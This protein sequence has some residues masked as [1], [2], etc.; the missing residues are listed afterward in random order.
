MSESH[1]VSLAFGNMTAGLLFLKRS[2]P[3]SLAEAW[4]VMQRAFVTAK[5]GSFSS[6]LLHLPETLA[7]GPHFEQSLRILGGTIQKTRMLP[8][9]GD[10]IKLTELF[11]KVAFTPSPITERARQFIVMP[12]GANADLSR[13]IGALAGLSEWR[14]SLHTTTGEKQ[15]HFFFLE[16]VSGMDE[17]LPMGLPGVPVVLAAMAEGVFVPPGLVHPFLPEYRFLFPPQQAGQRHCWVTNPQGLPEYFLLQETPDSGAPL[18]RKVTLKTVRSCCSFAT[19]ATDKIQVALELQ[20]SRTREGLPRDASRTVYRIETRAGE[21]GHLLLRF[22]DHAEAGIENFTYYIRPLGEGPNALIE[23]YLLAEERIQDEQSWPGL[24]RFYS[25]RILEDLNLP[26]FLP[27]NRH[28]AP[29]IEGLLRAAD[30]DEPLLLQLAETT[31]FGT[32]ANGYRADSEP[33]IA[34]LLPESNEQDWS[35]LHLENGRPLAEAIQATSRTY[36]REAIRRVLRVNPPSLEEEREHYEER[37]ID[38]GTREA[39]EIAELT[40]ECAQELR[41]AAVRMDAELQ[42]HELRL[43]DVEEVLSL[44]GALVTEHLPLSVCEYADRTLQIISEL[45]APQRSFL[46][47]LDMRANQLAQLQEDV[48]AL[49]RQATRDVERLTVERTTAEKEIENN[50]ERLAA[51]V[52]SLTSAANEL[53]GSVARAEEAA[54]QAVD[55]MQMRQAVLNRQLSAVMSLETQV[56]QEDARLDAVQ[57]DIERRERDAAERRRLQTVRRQ[58]L[59]RREREVQH[60]IRLAEQEQA[61]LNAIENVEIP[62]L[63][64]QLRDLEIEVAEFQKR[65]V[66]VS[67]AETTTKLSEETE[68]LAQ[69]KHTEVLLRERH[70]E[71]IQKVA[72]VK[73]AKTR[74]RKLRHDIVNEEKLLGANTELAPSNPTSEQEVEA[75][76]SKTSLFKRIFGGNGE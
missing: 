48:Q 76:K 65:G 15:S 26:I 7:S 66:E 50:Q 67:L 3:R 23:H 25:P 39:Q 74:E 64:K 68:Q 32:D 35:V 49:Q 44:A 27:E 11:E 53:S 28:F 69:L 20:K 45:A 33:K 70:R 71:L 2:L 42:E 22:L 10:E 47:Q 72:E 63:K 19:A 58:E 52:S 54:S 5:N 40:M 34:V 18:A 36:N 73:A 41:Q 57:N 56:F 62:A 59:E 55:A 17:A 60:S 1:L 14:T 13:L 24:T 12:R 8:G 30:A 29:D 9:A 6:F 16:S 21:F 75:S 4:Q 43:R 46:Q 61:R 37:W 31:G 51:R 38:A